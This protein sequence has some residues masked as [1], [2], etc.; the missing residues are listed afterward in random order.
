[1]VY[2]YISPSHPNINTTPHPTRRFVAAHALKEKVLSELGLDHRP[3]VKRK[4][5]LISP[6]LLALCKYVP[7]CIRMYM[8]EM[9][10]DGRDPLGY[11]NLFCIRTH[12]HRPM[13]EIPLLFGGQPPPA[14]DPYETDSDF[15]AEEQQA[16]PI[17]PTPAAPAGSGEGTEPPAP[18]AAGGGMDWTDAEQRK[19]FLKQR[20]AALKAEVRG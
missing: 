14:Y 11:S 7:T 1:M 17:P 15:E 10:D 2:I 5:L 8:H 16:P 13:K 4:A 12:T 3:K 19:A 9:P 20:A 6:S 18:P